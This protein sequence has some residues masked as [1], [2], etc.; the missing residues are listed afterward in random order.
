MN[1]GT[2]SVLWGV[3]C[4]AIHPIVVALAWRKYH[5]KWPQHLT[6]WVAI[7]CHDL[8]YWGCPEIDGPCGKQHPWRSAHIAEKVMKH[9]FRR[10]KAEQIATVMHVL[11]HSR[12]FCKEFG[13]A[14]S[15]LCAPD[16]LS[17]LFE[18]SWFYFLRAKLSG[19]L[20]EFVANA[21]RFGYVKDRLLDQWRWVGW[22]KRKVTYDF[23][24][25]NSV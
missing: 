1:V 22:Y 23:Q 16:K 7:V 6:E 10:G 5:G 8:G 14:M 11:G 12:S 3:H 25:K 17:V 19:E 13:F 9:V 21:A 18:P 15:P 2:K 4:F 20:P 24:K